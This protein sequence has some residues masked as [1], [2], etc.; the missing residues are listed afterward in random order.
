MMDNLKEIKLFL[1]SVDKKINPVIKEVL[2]LYVDKNNRE[3]INYQIFTN[4]KR[5]RPSLIILTCQM[6]GGKQNNAVY[7]AVAME[8]LHNCSLII[9]DIIDNDK[10]RRGE[11]TTW[12]KYGKSIAECISLTYMASVFQ[13]INKSRYSKEIIEVFAETTKTAVDGEILDLFFDQIKVDEPYVEKNRYRDVNKKDYLKM[14][15]KKTGSL[16]QACCEIGGICA[17]ANKNQMEILKQLGYN[18]G[19]AGQ[20]RDDMLDIF[21]KQD[22]I[23]KKRYKDIIEGNMG[24]VVFL[25]AMEELSKK[26]KQR[27]LK[28][29]SKKEKKSKDIKDIMLMIN[30]TK[31]E[32]KSLKLGRHFAEKAKQNLG[33]LPQNKHNKLLKIMC[34][35]IIERNK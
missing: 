31:A 17:N 10:I 15:E 13:A 25:F 6:M 29:M 9:D 8:I 2:D 12:I 35:Y 3:V 19:M 20:I 4:G 24:S 22:I 21:G 27:F 7:P 11:K 18:I 1:D 14:I 5:M 30:Q 16:I 26:D 32:E 33:A 28:I 23:K 34:D